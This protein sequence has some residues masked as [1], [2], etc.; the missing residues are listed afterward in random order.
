MLRMAIPY[1]TEMSQNQ[2]APPTYSSVEESPPSYY[3]L[4]IINMSTTDSDTPLPPNYED[5]ITPEE[6]LALDQQ[7]PSGRVS[8]IQ[9]RELPNIRRYNSPYIPPLQGPLIHRERLPQQDNGTAAASSLCCMILILSVVILVL[10]FNWPDDCKKT[11]FSNSKRDSG[12]G[13]FQINKTLP[14]HGQY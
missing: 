5:V 9:F 6:L 14:H 3:A 8:T 13:V 11:Y 7:Q 1:G 10:V 4:H 12:I 2:A